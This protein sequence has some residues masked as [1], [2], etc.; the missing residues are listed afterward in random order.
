MTMS[1]PA[2]LE[3]GMDLYEAIWT[4]RAMRRLK[5]D[6]IPEGVLRSILDAAIRAASGGNTQAWAFVVV[7]DPALKE[8]IGAL[9]QPAVAELFGT[10]TRYGRAMASPD[11]AV[12]EPVRRMAASVRYMVDH[13]HAAPALVFACL[14]LGSNPGSVTSGASIYPAV[15]NLMLAARAHGV[16]STL[17]TMHRRR[18]DEVRSLL[19]IPSTVETMAMIPLGY[20]LGRWGVAARRPLEEVA[21]DNRWGEPWR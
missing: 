5:P 13:L 3:T 17:T 11:P 16:G 10:E 1:E 4:T 18:Q 6:P 7:R 2:I 9:I 20:P 14:D 12:A 21:F 19:G 8:Q 15:Q